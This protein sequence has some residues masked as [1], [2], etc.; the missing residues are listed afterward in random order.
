MISGKNYIGNTLSNKGHNTFKAY[1]SNEF[2]YLDTDFY[3]ANKEEVDL[4]LELAATAFYSYRNFS[5][6]KRAEFLE[7]IAEEIMNFGD[8]LVSTAMLETALPEGR[9]IG[10]RGRTVNQLK[11]FA[12]LLKEGSWVEASIDV[13]IPDRDPIPK[14]DLRRYRQAVGPVVVFGASNFPLA[15]STAG[16]D[17]ASALAAGCPV[18]VKAHPS[19]PGTNELVASAIIKAAE[20]TNMPNGVFSSLNDSRFE[21]GRQLVLHP[22][23]K[24]VAFTGSFAGGKALFDLSNTRSEPI[25]VFAEMG[26]VNPVFILPNKMRDEYDSIAA[27]LAGSITLGIGQFCTNP[28]LIITINNDSLDSFINSLSKNISSTNSGKMLNSHIAENYI[29]KRNRMLTEKGIKLEGSA[30]V[31]QGLAN[32]TIV[33]VDAEKF[34]GNPKLHEEVFGPFSLIIK[35]DNVTEMREV[36][37]TLQGQ[38]TATVQATESELEEYS[39]IINLIKDK[40]GRLIFN[41]VPTGVEV[42]S[43]MQHG[44]PFPA[45]TDSRFTSVGTDAIKRFTRPISYQDWPDHLLPAELQNNNPLNIWRWINSNFT[46]DRI[47]SNV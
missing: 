27:N 20:T 4:A 39:E 18:I 3:C 15:F 38:L 37:Q 19:H 26:S 25:P 13:A 29:A 46:K 12:K 35:C 44:G 2:K 31:K 36:T 32:A 40:V 21:V 28:G 7:A 16:G 10:E 1:D 43:S 23:V 41:G 24:S 42:C 22:N 11:M 30:E 45:T 5:G 8:E 34:I 14:P 9:I 17:T 6:E 33:S 47:E